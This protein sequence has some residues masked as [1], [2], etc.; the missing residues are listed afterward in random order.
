M[1]GDRSRPIKGDRI[2]CPECHRWVGYWPDKADYHRCHLM[3]HR[4]REFSRH[5][6][7]GPWC[8]GREYIG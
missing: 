8:D 3:P 5:G 2:E 7:N 6:F 4:T 1:D